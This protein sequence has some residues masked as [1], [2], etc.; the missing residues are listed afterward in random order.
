L[1]NSISSC[2]R[3]IGLR[4]YWG[5]EFDPLGLLDVI[6]HVTIL[7]SRTPFPIGGPLEPCLYLQRFPIISTVTQWLTRP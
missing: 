1:L 7:I 3:D 5:Y 6:G 4:A 2:F